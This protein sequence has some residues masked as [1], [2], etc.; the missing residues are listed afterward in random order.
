MNSELVSHDELMSLLSYESETG[1]FHWIFSKN[2]RIKP[3]QPAGKLDNHGYLIINVNKKSYKAH[4]LAWFYFYGEWPD[5]QIDHINRIR[6]DNRISNLRLAT[7]SENV[8]NRDPQSNNKCGLKGVFFC[9]RDKRWIAQIGVNKKQRRI[10]SF[11]NKE[12]A[13]AAYLQEAALI[14]THNPCYQKDHHDNHP[15]RLA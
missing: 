10:G 5:K 11:S 1:E 14:H 6:N 2:N 13:Y 12:D 8:Q 9:K 3:G 4:R 15:H 7:H